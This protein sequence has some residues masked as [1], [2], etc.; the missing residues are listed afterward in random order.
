MKLSMDRL[1]WMA[2]MTI[3]SQLSLYYNIVYVM[4]ILSYYLRILQ[5]YP[6][7]STY[8]N[9]CFLIF[10][11]SCNIHQRAKL[12]IHSTVEVVFSGVQYSAISHI[13][14]LIYRINIENRAGMIKICL[15]IIFLIHVQNPGNLYMFFILQTANIYRII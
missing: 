1:P 6:L 9:N 10:H 11:W 12:F 4:L 15:G 13:I 14:R 7:H 5:F 3:Y 8:N 2:T